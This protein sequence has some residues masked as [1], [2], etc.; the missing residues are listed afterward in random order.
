MAPVDTTPDY[1]G[2]G[3]AAL[4]AL[5]GIMGGVKRGSKISLVAGVGSAIAAGYGANRVS[6]SPADVIPSLVTSSALLL[7]MGWRFYQG[8]KFMPAGLVIVI[9]LLRVE[10]FIEQNSRG[11]RFLN[12]T[13]RLL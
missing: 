11:S 8:R 5:G 13:K 12:L 9:V 1:L 10:L 6:K 4:L 7:L 3:Y 2:Y